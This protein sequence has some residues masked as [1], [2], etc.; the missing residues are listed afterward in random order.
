[1]TPNIPLI[2]WEPD[3][4]PTR[5]GTIVDV[6]NMVPTRRGYAPE[7]GFA[8]S[9]TYALSITTEPHS[10]Q[11]VGITPYVAYGSTI[12]GFVSGAWTDLSRSGTAY[13]APSISNPWRFAQFT[14]A[15]NT[16]VT[17]AAQFQNGLQAREYGTA[18]L[19][20]DV[21]SAPWA[22]TIA[23]QRGF[24][25][26]GAYTYGGAGY[27]DN[28]WIC[29]AL[30]D[31]TDW[32]NDIATQSA[33]GRLTATP[34]AIVRLLAFRDYVIAFKRYS[35]Y[36]GQYVGAADNT[37]AW[38]VI[39]HSVG[40]ASHDAVVEVDGVLYWMA[41]DGFYRWA[42]GT[43]ERIQS[44]PWEWLVEQATF[45]TGFDTG[46]QCVYDPAQ[47]TIRWVLNL[48]T[49]GVR[50]AL[51]YHPESNR[52]GRADATGVIRTFTLPGA[53]TR[54][55]PQ[56]DSLFYEVCPAY[57]VQ[58][59]A[60]YVLSTMT[61]APTDSSF[62]TGDIGDDDDVF[63]LTRARTRFLTAPTASYVTHYYRQSLGETLTTGATVIRAD[64]KYDVS[65]S[66]RWHRLKFAQSGA[67]EVTGF[68]IES[69]RAGKR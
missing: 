11:T 7:S 47:R 61:A 38:P 19:F 43:V 67:C 63:V 2:A 54:R 68:R 58:S 40:L 22:D 56:G 3:G 5:P 26:L 46:A 62:T 59:G 17:L 8:A 52:W 14:D 31:H 10:A 13:S 66:A 29:S 27:A 64:G 42:G 12:S 6:E 21:P 4:D 15:T 36:R 65:H 50:I 35:M 24:V 44:A 39:S 34:G 1:M 57:M 37:W 33:S 9:S 30:E 16:T 48:A 49:A 25:L 23:V 20:A 41:M 60:N 32:T 51:I 69:P 18:D 28:G 45:G 53:S 55:Q